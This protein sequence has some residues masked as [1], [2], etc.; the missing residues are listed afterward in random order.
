MTA[1][2]TF[3]IFGS[4]RTKKTSQRIFRNRRTGSRFVM[5]SAQSVAWE[6]DA[7]LQLN[8]QWR[9]RSA[10]AVPMTMAATFYRTRRTG[11]LSNFIGALCDA[12]QKARVVS[13]DKLIDSF[14][15]CRL[16]IDRARPR[17]EVTLTWDAEQGVTP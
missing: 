8:S 17:V 10:V 4:P 14:D 2:A 7:A 1:T 13:N 6:N 5:Q 16:D 15:G 9:G 3:T 12:L 11:D